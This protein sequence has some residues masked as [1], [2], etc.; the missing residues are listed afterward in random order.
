MTYDTACGFVSKLDPSRLFRDQKDA[1]AHDR[2]AAC[3]ELS[4]QL[5]DA[6]DAAIV[7]PSLVRLRA[8]VRFIA[9]AIE[10]S[11]AEQTLVRSDVP[12]EGDAL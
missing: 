9:D 10:H 12:K 4:Y 6:F 8:A 1:E 5:S 11:E 7:D 2:N 3:R